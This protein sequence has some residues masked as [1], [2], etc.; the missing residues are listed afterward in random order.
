M[1][2]TI[3]TSEPPYV[4]GAAYPP[5]IAI[6]VAR[7]YWV[8][9]NRRRP[10]P[11]CGHR[12]YCEVSVDGQWC[13]CMYHASDRPWTKRQGGWL[14]PLLD[15]ALD[16]AGDTPTRTAAAVE[17]TPPAAD[18]DTLDAV[19]RRLHT[20]C[21]LAD[22]DRALL[23]GPGHGLTDDQARALCATV[24]NDME[25]R[26][27]VLNPLVDAVGVKTLLAVPGF[28]LTENT[29]VDLVGA[30]LLL[31]RHDVRGRLT[32]AQWRLRHP[33][34][35]QPR[36]IYLTSTRVHGPSPGSAP[37]VARPP[38]KVHSHTIWITEGIKKAM[39]VADTRG[40][41]TIGL[42]GAATWR[43]AL[44][45]TR[46]L[47]AR[48][49]V[50]ALD[51]DTAPPAKEMVDRCRRGL[52]HALA[53]SG[54]QVILASWPAEVAK[55]VDDLI[56]SGVAPLL[57]PANARGARRLALTRPPGRRLPGVTRPSG[58]RLAEVTR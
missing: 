38:G 17:P 11:Q 32:G 39:V 33:K 7:G 6:S 1:N 13:H 51:Q 28:Y 14:H 52:A 5:S 37:H 9:T 2:A 16:A 25:S 29:R 19:Y 50:I 58:R 56:Q 27:R 21:P 35:G 55:G 12:G 20:L 4:E 49:V 43:Q 26:R 57:T 3:E 8:G 10:C 24:P 15:G 18:P 45:V 47:A 42:L 34:E 46:E 54:C 53:R 23:T 40:V 30:G 44:P 31:F 36:Y 48:T 22:D 41:V